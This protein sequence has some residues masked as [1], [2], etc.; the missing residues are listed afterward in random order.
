MRSKFDA[1]TDACTLGDICTPNVLLGLWVTPRALALR[2]GC[3][4]LG[5]EGLRRLCAGES[6]VELPRATGVQLRVQDLKV[7]RTEAIAG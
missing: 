5:P 6:P 7:S 2:T 3:V 1:L 4:V